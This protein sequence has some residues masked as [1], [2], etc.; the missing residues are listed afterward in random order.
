MGLFSLTT[1]STYTTLSTLFDW[2]WMW[3]ACAARQC[4]CDLGVVI[5][6]GLTTVSV[7]YKETPK[8][9]V[10]DRYFVACLKIVPKDLGHLFPVSFACRRNYSK[11]KNTSSSSSASSVISFVTK[12]KKLVVCSEVKVMEK[13]LF[14][15][16]SSIS[17]FRASSNSF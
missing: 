6:Q 9:I 7:S 1:F 4:V 13:A 3:V 15:Y 2:L 8:S 17:F 5:S 12:S 14:T 11:A 10:N 16:K